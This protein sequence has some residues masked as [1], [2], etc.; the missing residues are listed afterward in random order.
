MLRLHLEPTL[1]RLGLMKIDGT[2]QITPDGIDILKEID[3]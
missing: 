2:R 3:G 1:V